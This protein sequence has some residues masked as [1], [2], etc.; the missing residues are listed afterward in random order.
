VTT[1]AV[2]AVAG[3]PGP[4][5]LKLGGELI[6]PGS[7]LTSVVAAIAEICARGLPLVVVH[8]GGKEID[9]ALRVAGLAKQQVDGLRITD[10][11]TLD[12]VVSVLAGT[13]NTRFVAALAAAGVAAVGLTGADA[14]CGLAD[15]APPHRAVDGRIVDLGRVGEPSG[16]SDVRLLTTLVRDHFVPVVACIGATRTGGLLNVNA[17]TL[18]AHLAA[19]L[20]AR[21]LIV[22]GTT[23]GVLD[24]RGTT[25]P[26]LD[27]A[28]VATLVNSGTATAG[29]VAKLRACEHALEAGVGDVVIVDGRTSAAIALAATGEVPMDATRLMRTVVTA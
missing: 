12:V 20:H 23:A 10:E 6:E 8:G 4:F 17:D 18:A 27:A 29:M 21:R 11:P 9:A 1:C 28:G 24:A 5:V 13:V 7:H 16:D 26:T 15:E 2:A 14:Q 22:A 3:G 25:A 19:R